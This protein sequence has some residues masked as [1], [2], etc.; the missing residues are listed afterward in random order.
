MRGLQEAKSSNETWPSH[1]LS[2]LFVLALGSPSSYCCASSP[3]KNKILAIASASS[4]ASDAVHTKISVGLL[5]ALLGRESQVGASQRRNL[6]R[7]KMAK[8]AKFRLS[9]DR[10]P[11]TRRTVRPVWPVRSWRRAC[12][13]E[14]GRLRICQ[15]PDISGGGQGLWSPFG[16]P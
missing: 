11:T 10:D 4:V 13:A 2:P 14:E 15:K 9:I 5:V 16:R 7:Q 8:S 1:F 12:M 3:L 6:R